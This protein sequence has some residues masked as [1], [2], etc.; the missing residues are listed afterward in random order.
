MGLKD[1]RPV[2][3]YLR[4]YRFFIKRIQE[5]EIN[6]KELERRKETKAL[7]CLKPKVLDD[8]GVWVNEP[9]DKVGEA[10]VMIL[11]V[12]A[13][14]I[15]EIS[16]KMQELF[17]QLA[18]MESVLD[19]SGLSEVEYRF[20]QCYY[21]EGREMVSLRMEMGYSERGMRDIKLRALKKIKR[22]ME[23][24]GIPQQNTSAMLSVKG[25]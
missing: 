15:K 25:G 1:F 2:E 20:I 14:R 13:N 11:D 21:F 23:Q 24:K 19:A 4:G 18:K 10:V 12:Y 8:S 16:D 22:Q 17:G 5:C 7:D 9:T 3:D 6:L